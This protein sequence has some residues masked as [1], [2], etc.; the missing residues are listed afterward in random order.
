MVSTATELNPHGFVERD[1]PQHVKPGAFGYQ[2][3]KG[4]R[5]GTD[6][7]GMAFIASMLVKSRP[8]T[9]LFMSPGPI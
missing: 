7:R 3:I 5:F 1:L 4:F 8:V 2:L 6:N 9:H